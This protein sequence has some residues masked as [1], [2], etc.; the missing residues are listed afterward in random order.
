M[1][2]RSKGRPIHGL[3]I[4]DKPAGLTSNTALQ[5]VKRSLGAAKAGHTGALDPLATGV[6]PL[7]FG[8]A[9]KFSQIL[10][11]ADKE[12][13]TKALLG[14]QTT[15]ADAEGDVI[16]EKPVPAD[17]NLNVFNRVL[18]KFKGAQ[19]QVPSMFS[20]LKY[21]GVP[22]Y[23][24]ARKGK[25]V[26]RKARDIF[27]YELQVI[28]W[29]LPFV[30]L[31]VRCSKGTYIRNLV[32][33]IGFEIGCGAHVTELRRTQSG[34]YSLAQ[35]VSFKCFEQS[36]AEGDT[37]ELIR[38]VDSALM[39]FSKISLNEVQSG[40]II[41]GQTVKISPPENPVRTDVLLRLYAESSGRF[42]GLGMLS[43]AHE[44]RSIR[45]INPNAL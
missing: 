43:A 33:D 28:G 36:L 6:L 9:T 5:T 25:E 8:E 42:L 44:L 45:L 34:P 16:A 32:E 27:I 20:A 1:V 10:L 14:K 17:L 24:L 26:E 41:H 21:Q 7:C 2:R 18:D 29:D 38:P 13:I 37:T 22:L 19:K 40:S 11:E 31:K 4:L 12:Y 3:I 39:H 15:T 35:T 30:E 23:K